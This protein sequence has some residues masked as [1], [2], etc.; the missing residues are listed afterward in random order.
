M[1]SGGSR[2][3]A[4]A[5]DELVAAGAGAD[6]ELM[7]RRRASG[8]GGACGR[9]GGGE[10]ARSGWR[11]SR[12]CEVAA[13]LW[14]ASARATGELEV[15]REI[16]SHLAAV[17]S[18]GVWSWWRRNRERVRA[19]RC[20]VHG[21]GQNLTVTPMSTISSITLL[22]TFV[23][24]DLADLQETVQLGYDEGV[25]ILKASLQSKTVLTDVFLGS[26]KEPGSA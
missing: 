10:L 23:V 3:C 13:E 18:L 19:G 16:R 7:A 12:L 24:R 25:A 17:A 5:G 6:G 20:D 22:N 8:G 9:A 4:R 2:A 15:G 14:A 11:Q 26:K 21:V 1:A